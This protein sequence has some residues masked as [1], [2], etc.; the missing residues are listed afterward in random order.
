MPS[1]RI[2]FFMSFN[3]HGNLACVNA[4]F[5][6]SSTIDIPLSLIPHNH[7]IWY[8]FNMK[9]NF[10]N[11]LHPGYSSW[12]NSANKSSKPSPFPQFPLEVDGISV[13]SCCSHDPGL[14]SLD[15]F[16]L[17]SGKRLSKRFKVEY[18]SA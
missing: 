7:L 18:K 13:S 17:I 2:T 1:F 8:N 11:L 14:C 3:E 4:S 10:V 9:D 15:I 5:S 12:I 16:V 6:I